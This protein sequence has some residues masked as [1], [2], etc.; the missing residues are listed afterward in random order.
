MMKKIL[1]GVFAHPDDEAFGPSGMLYKAASSGTDVHLILVTDG[2]AGVNSAGHEDLAA[3]RLKEWQASGALIGAKSM[4]ALGY[5]DGTLNNNLYLEIAEKLIDHIKQTITDYDEPT[6]LTMLT[7]DPGGLT[8]HLD[9]IA[10][11]MMATFTYL[12]LRDEP[13]AGC[14]VGKLK[15]ACISD[16]VM[17]SANTNWLY[18]PAGRQNS[19]C[20]EVID[21]SDIFDKKVEIMQAHATQK[22]DMDSL[23]SRGREAVAVEYYWYY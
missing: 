13:P 4:E 21:V 12:K 9:H 18:M 6:E 16:E 14:D 11:S 3:V 1:F 5:K 10:V 19:E 7:I 23:L 17:P 8:G 22:H 15:Y 2:G 20:D